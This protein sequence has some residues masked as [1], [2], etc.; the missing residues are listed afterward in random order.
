[1]VD[2]G[3]KIAHHVRGWTG[4]YRMVKGQRSKGEN[5]ISKSL[6]LL[7]SPPMARFRARAKAFILTFPQTS[8][9]VQRK[10][11]NDGG[12]FLES[13]QRDFESPVCIR[14]GRESHSDGGIHFHVFLSFESP[15]T[16]QSSDAFDY[17][18]S[19]GNIKSVRTTPR[20]V[21]DYV[22]K[23]DDV[24]YEYGTAPDETGNDAG[25]NSARWHDIVGCDSKESFL[26]AVR[27]QAPRDWV[28]SLDR[29]LAY[30]E[31]AYPTIVPEYQSPAVA[32]AYERIPGLAGWKRQAA[33]GTAVG[34]R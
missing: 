12:T 15:V 23:D 25:S 31:Y 19:H 27:S 18:G 28:L 8:E 16:V 11:V 7:T 14:I 22:G 24:V 29:I 6:S 10:F 20:K 21:Y 2:L 26:S 3:K 17:F 5:N 33:I 9:D 32:T 34:E 1:M 13:V 30:A 4:I